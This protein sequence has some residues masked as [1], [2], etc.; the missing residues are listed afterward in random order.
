MQALEPVVFLRATPP[1][2]ALPQALFDEAAR[3]LEVGFYPA[4]MRLAEAGGAPLEHLYVIRTGSVR[5]D[6]DGE[7]LQTLEEGETF[8]YTSLIT[9]KATLDVTVEQDLLAY[10]VPR[11]QFER[12]LTDASFAGHF[13]V[14]LAARLRSSLQHSTVATF[15]V[16]LTQGVGQLVRRGPVWIEPGATVG[17]AAR[18]M[19]AEKV[20]SVL[21]RSDPA[22][23]V[24]DRDFRAR[25]LATDRGPKTAVTEV[26]SQPVATVPAAMPIFEAWRTLLESGVH[27]LAVMRGREI[28]GV[29][30]ANDLL[31]C[32]AQGP[33]PMLRSVD[34]LTGRD[35]LAG[36][37]QRVAEMA[38]SLLSGGLEATTVAGFVAR[39][40]GALLQKLLAWA[41]ADLGPRPGPYAWLLFG[42][43]GRMEQTLLTDMDN[44]LAFDDAAADARSWYQALADRVVHDLEVAGF[45]RCPGGRMAS[46][47]LGTVSYWRR[48]IADAIER[49]PLEAAVFF[50]YRR[51][52]GALDTAPLDAA[53]VRARYDRLFVRRLAKGALAFG[54]PARLLLRESSR[55]DLKAEGISPV[56]YLA[57]CYAV[58]VGSSARG[59]LDRLDAARAAGLMGEETHAEVTEA[60]RFLL[61]LR[62]RVQLRRLADREPPSDEV[63]VATLSPLERNRL[64]ES[65][66]AI[67]R[68]Q[69]KAAFHY[70][71]EFT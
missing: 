21:V 13:A 16:D 60:Y 43:E 41:E 38:S 18:L 56:V 69:E 14:E 28:V 35:R 67:R 9:R 46:R 15:Q 5:I 58:E 70:Q 19:R 54:P 25:V 48:E 40:D 6:R 10:R 20:S 59:T 64:K 39:L 66:V 32:S 33:L 68:W 47:W 50:D 8:G 1:F 71:P 22:G 53:L 63:T 3:A 37:A 51:G 24:T 36:H 29:V 45:P 2:H 44:G 23:I 34:L 17:E 4:G 42:S 7:T 65:L 55:I 27:H 11:S 57:R 61:G 26:F 62:L 30:T 31:R 52:A 12:L 49:R